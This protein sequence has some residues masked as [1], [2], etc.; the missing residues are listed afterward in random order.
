MDE[1]IFFPP[2]EIKLVASISKVFVA[3]EIQRVSMANLS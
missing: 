1:G 3:M 2:G